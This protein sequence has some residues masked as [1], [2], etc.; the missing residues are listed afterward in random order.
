M[1]QEQVEMQNNQILKIINKNLVNK[2][3][4]RLD[5]VEENQWT[6]WIY[7]EGNTKQ[8]RKK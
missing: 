7:P 8:K 1:K 4:I 5:I 6:G 3:N 2:L